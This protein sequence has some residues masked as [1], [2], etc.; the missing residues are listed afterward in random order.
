MS[1]WNWYPCETNPSQGDTSNPCQGD[2]Q[3]SILRA[4]E[5]QLR[6][7]EA[8]IV[9]NPEPASEPDKHILHTEHLTQRYQFRLTQNPRPHQLA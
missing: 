1:L 8:R 5:E 6:A 7:R 2:T 3:R 9:D 4:S